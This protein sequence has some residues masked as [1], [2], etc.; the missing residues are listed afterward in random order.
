VSAV[1]LII[2]NI[3]TNVSIIIVNKYVFKVYE[4]NY[5]TLVT[6]LHFVFTA[7]GLRI[8]AKFGLFEMKPLTALQ[9]LP[10]AA[11]YALCTPL[12]NLSLAFNSVGFYQMMKILTTPYV[13]LVEWWFYGATFS[14]PIKFSLFL[15]TVGVIFASVNDVEFNWLGAT[16]AIVCMIITAQYQIYVGTKQKELGVNSTQLLTNMVPVSALIV[17]VLT[18]FLDATGIFFAQEN[19]LVNYEFTAEAVLAVFGSAVLAVFVNMSIF[20]LIGATS[21]VTYNVVGHFK[22]V[23]ILAFSFVVFDT[24]FN[25][26]NVLGMILA[27]AGM[28]LYTHI[29]MNAPPAPPKPAPVPTNSATSPLTAKDV[30]EED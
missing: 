3:F 23:L 1:G 11:C 9:V 26:K 30:D 16:Y 29:K 13:A 2:L 19:S 7:I 27:L 15:V 10:L 25:G 4:F 8:M 14:D 28:I 21:P 20:L 18:P 5:A 17:L 22:T 6:F 12:S 24:P